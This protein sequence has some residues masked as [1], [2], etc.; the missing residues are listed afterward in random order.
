[1][2]VEKKSQKSSEYME[3]FKNW[4][5]FDTSIVI[6]A[7]EYKANVPAQ[8]GWVHRHYW[9][10]KEGPFYEFAV[11]NSG[12]CTVCKEAIPEYIL[13]HAEFQNLGKKLGKI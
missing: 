7:W 6:G 10:G 4:P 2:S 1:M 13:I 9:E 5:E 3:S 12:I 11:G 8:N